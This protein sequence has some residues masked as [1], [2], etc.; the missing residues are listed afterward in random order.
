MS[1]SGLQIVGGKR[2]IVYLCLSVLSETMTAGNGI[3]KPEFER[4]NTYCDWKNGDFTYISSL[5]GQYKGYQ[6]I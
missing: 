3:T 4:Q 1:P 5:T 6:K 2:V